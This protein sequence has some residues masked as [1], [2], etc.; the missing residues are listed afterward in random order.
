[1]RL[2]STP[3]LGGTVE[4]QLWYR[5]QSMVDVGNGVLHITAEHFPVDSSGVSLITLDM[6]AT[7]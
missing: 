3:S 5:V 1:V 6:L 2:A 4:D 7:A